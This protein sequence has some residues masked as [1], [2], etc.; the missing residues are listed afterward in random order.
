MLPSH[1]ASRKSEIENKKSADILGILTKSRKSVKVPTLGIMMYKFKNDPPQ[2]YTMRRFYTPIKNI[3]GRKWALFV[4]P[5]HPPQESSC[6]SCIWIVARNRK[7]DS[8]GG[9]GGIE[10]HHS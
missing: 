6:A 7:V 3:L 10:K 9:D 4:A 2:F 8:S 5:P 1:Q